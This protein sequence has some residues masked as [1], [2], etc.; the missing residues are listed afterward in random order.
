M[1]V[2]HRVLGSCVE[3]VRKRVAIVP[4]SVV[5][6]VGG[7]VPA[8]SEIVVEGK[9]NGKRKPYFHASSHTDTHTPIVSLEPSFKVSAITMR[10]NPIYRHIQ[11]N[12]FTEHHS[13]GDFMVMAP[14]LQM[15][16]ANLLPVNDVHMPLHSC[17]NCGIIQMTSNN[18]MEVREAMQT[19][20][21]NPN[22]PRLSTIASRSN[23]AL[24]WHVR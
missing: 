9:I 13:F 8:M 16:R 17:G 6:A 1:S 10:K 14:M 22:A 19:A 12:R 3:L 18:K 15:L 7:A 23:V 4:I 2:V 24:N 5:L 11:P 21:A 20:T